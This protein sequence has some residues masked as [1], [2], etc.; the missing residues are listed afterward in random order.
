MS[1]ILPLILVAAAYLTL[2]S[3]KKESGTAIT[4]LADALAQAWNYEE[5]DDAS[6]AETEAVLAK[7]PRDKTLYL[8]GFQWGEP[9]S[10]NPLNGYPDWP[11]RPEFNLMYEHLTEYNSM[12]D[13][14][15]PAIGRI[16]QSNKDYISLIL[17]SLARWSDGK[18]LTSADVLFSY[19]L[20]LTNPDA[21]CSYIQ[22]F[23][24]E[25]TVD[26]V[27]TVIRN[28]AGDSVAVKAEERVFL[29]VDKTD[30]NNPL[31]VLD[32]TSTVPILPKHIFEPLLKAA[33]GSVSEVSNDPMNRPQVVSGPYN[34]Y[35]YSN[36]KIVI[37]RRDDYWG[38]EAFHSGKKPAPEYIVHPIYKGNE[39]AST[40]L[41]NGELDISSNYTPR[42]WLKDG[43]KTW[44]DAEPYFMPGSIPMFIINT[45][46]PPL[47][48]KHYRRAMAFAIDYEKIKKLAVSGYTTDIQS[49]LILPFSAESTYFSREE[50]DKYGATKYD[51][52]RAKEELE[53][54]G[55]K[56]LYDKKGNL[57]CVVDAY[58]DTMPTVGIMSPS[59]WTDFESVVRIAITGMRA[60]GI[61]IRPNFVDDTQYWPAQTTGNFDLFFDT[62]VAMMAK[63][64]PWSR[65]EGVMSAKNWKAVGQ[66]MYENIGRWNNPNVENFIPQIDSL[67]HIIPLLEN[68]NE[69]KEAYTL[70]NRYYM[71]EQPTI[72]VLY[73]PEEY[74]E[75]STKYWTNFPTSAKPYAPPRMPVAAAG[76]RMLWE[77]VPTA[78]GN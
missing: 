5:Q 43:V 72:P 59:G 7:L 63:S 4:T 10:F 62:P 48:N 73:R 6:D 1:K 51:P 8:V 49:G 21:P 65:F 35:M 19:N 41:K 39:H 27:K 11:S 34:L 28:E 24:K 16:E 50:V 76:T 46:R 38:N 58:G 30:R 67:L 37:R 14:I 40:A 31:S 52:E 20:S 33:G 32:Q 71:E 18:P 13:D 22:G 9:H 2:S 78:G 17:N 25:L 66:K 12:T 75:F 74:Y 55:F 3:C 15:E 56:S 53:L 57:I 26:T 36:E 70:L 68:E 64:T 47:D 60:V 69:K 54:G 77:I 42:I 44:F 61:D 29:W 23:I 45:T